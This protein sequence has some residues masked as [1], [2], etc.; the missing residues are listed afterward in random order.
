MDRG[1]LISCRA[2]PIISNEHQRGKRVGLHCALQGT[3]LMRAT[4]CQIEGNKDFLREALVV[5]LV[6]GQSHTTLDVS[7]TVLGDPRMATRGQ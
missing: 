7:V 2:S 1:E 3:T 6:L 4:R 5:L